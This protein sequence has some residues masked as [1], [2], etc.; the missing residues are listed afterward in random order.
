MT[1]ISVQRLLF[2]NDLINRTKPTKE[3]ARELQPAKMFLTN[4]VFDIFVSQLLGYA[5][6][7]GGISSNLALANTIATGRLSDD[8]RNNIEILIICL[9]DL[10][11]MG[12]V[13]VIS[14]ASLESK[15][16]LMTLRKVPRSLLLEK[17]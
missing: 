1:A 15:Y 17:R 6:I 2:R 9:S 4:N 5:R 11:A 13:E 16:F 14:V 8:S 3:A 12:T 10:P 7:P